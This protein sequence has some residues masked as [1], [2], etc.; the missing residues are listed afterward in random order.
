MEEGE[1]EGRKGT[2][3]SVG[4][5]HFAIAIEHSYLVLIN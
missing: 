4:A 1:G 3:L 2:S 5:F